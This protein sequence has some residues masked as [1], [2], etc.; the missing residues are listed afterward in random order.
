MQLGSTRMNYLQQIN[1]YA[2]DLAILYNW[3]NLWICTDE[4]SS[5]Y[6]LQ[7]AAQLL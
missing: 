2:N 6:D 4:T 7:F 5:I 1:I 3:S